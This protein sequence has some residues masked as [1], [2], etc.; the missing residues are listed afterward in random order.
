[1][2]QWVSRRPVIAEGRVRSQ[3]SPCGIFGLQSDTG[4]GF[5]PRTS[6]RRSQY[7]STKLQYSSLI[8]LL[9]EGQAGE[10]CEVYNTTMLLRTF[11]SNR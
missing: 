8:L 4:T 10:G 6:I 11:G 3:A 1:M 9:V 5:S 7:H 2:T